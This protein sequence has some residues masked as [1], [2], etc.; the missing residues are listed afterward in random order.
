MTETILETHRLTWQKKPILREL[1]HHYYQRMVS[2]L[3]PGMTLEIGGG[4]GN[5]KSYLNDVISTDIVATPWL[6]TTCDAQALPFQSLCF[7]NI[8]MLDVLH[9][10]ERPYRFFKEASRTLK[11]GGRIILLEPA[12]TKLSWFFYHFLHPEPVDLTA[13]P[14]DDAP[15]TANRLPFDANQAI[16]ELLFG[17]FLPE[18]NQVFPELKVSRKDYLALASYPLSG[19]FRWWSLIPTLALPALLAIEK[20]LEPLLAQYLGF[21]MLVVLEKQ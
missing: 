3:K 6:D 12:I 17:Q 18:F 21:R 4:S 7:D 10:I 14:L 13:N 15:L 11:P 20:W 8:V 1:Y 5:L 16:P 2:Q 9:H 19:G